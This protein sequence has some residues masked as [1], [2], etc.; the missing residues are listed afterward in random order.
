MILKTKKQTKMRQNQVGT[1]ILDDFNKIWE[2]GGEH[3]KCK[4]ETN[5]VLVL[6]GK[7]DYKNQLILN[8][9]IKT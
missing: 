7:V 3:G 8:S 2:I 5:E 1:K 4:N 6:N 9:D